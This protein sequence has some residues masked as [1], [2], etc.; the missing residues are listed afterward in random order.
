MV[1]GAD[2]ESYSS[3]DEMAEDISAGE[4]PS[5]YELLAYLWQNR[6]N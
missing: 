6:H 1:L 4:Y 3:L 5:I 2:A